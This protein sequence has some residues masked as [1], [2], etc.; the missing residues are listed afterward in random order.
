VLRAL[1]V[2]KQPHHRHDGS[3][4]GTSILHFGAALPNVRALIAVESTSAT[5]FGGFSPIH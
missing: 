5:H 3:R 1:R 4:T 2:V